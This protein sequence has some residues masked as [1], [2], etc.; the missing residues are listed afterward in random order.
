MATFR[1]GR[2]IDIHWQGYEIVGPANT[3]FS[4]PDQLYEEF[5][6]DISPVEP[7]LEWID[8]NEFLTLSNEVSTSTLSASLPIALATSTSGKTISLSSST[9][10]NGYLLAA[11]GTGG[12][13]WTPASTSSLTS[14]IGVSPI[15]TVISGGTVSVSLDANYQTAGTYVNAVIGTSPASVL[16]ASGTST[17][18]INQS[19]ITGATAATNAQVVRFYVKNTTGTTIPKGSAVYVSGATGDNAL[20]SLAS[21]TSDPSSSKTLGITAE[22]IATDAFGYVVE[23]GYLTDI[24]TSATTAGAAVWLGNTPGSLVFVSP[25]AEPSHAVYLG[26]VV[27]VQSNNGSILVK[28]QNGYEID[29]LHDVSAASPTDLDILQYKGSSS[30]W[31]K[32][33]ISNAGIAASVHTHPYQDAGTYVTAVNGTAPITAST[34]TAGIVTVGLSANYQTAGTYVTA[35]NGSAPIATS[36]NTAGIV[37]VSLSASYAS[38][39]H[40]HSTSSI[41]SGNFAATVSGG[42]GVTV[43][44]GTGNAS[45]P[46]VSIGQAVATTSDV[47]FSKITGTGI[48]SAPNVKIG[49]VT[50]N[51]V[52][53]DMTAAAVTGLSVPTT[54]GGAV[55]LVTAITSAN[56]YRS[57]AATNATFTG[58]NL[59]G[60]TVYLFR[61][62]TTSTGVWYLVYGE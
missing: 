37:S 47:T 53:N 27:R 42:T 5:D 56:A 18:S 3:V 30:L 59:T 22:A 24:D 12:T 38:S 50:V 9:A 54:A 28:V 1:F 52:A 39:V 23:A 10:L 35:V 8:T 21:A 25:P 19:A 34:S 60:F 33:S 32:A 58:T 26:V 48:F 13:I 4:I 41:T 44:G 11:D 51:P 20:I 6:A 61:T 31:T 45:T 49:S 57:V 62:N 7:T 15:S 40:T 29:E 16:T 55:I 43:T 14:V 46:T 36:T 17:V 2:A